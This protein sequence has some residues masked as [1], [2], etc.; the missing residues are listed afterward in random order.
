MKTMT[1][2]EIKA[3]FE[4]ITDALGEWVASDQSPCGPVVAYFDDGESSPWRIT[5]DWN[6]ES[7]ATLDEAVAGAEAWAA[8]YAEQDAENNRVAAEIQEQEEFFAE[9]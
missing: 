4:A 9:E 3:G 7:F 6:T 1:E 5:D 2:A 8:V